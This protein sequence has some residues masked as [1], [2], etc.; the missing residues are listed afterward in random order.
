MTSRAIFCYAYDSVTMTARQE[1]Q[2]MG[3]LYM[4]YVAVRY[5]QAKE[6]N[7]E[8]KR[9]IYHAVISASHA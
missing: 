5:Y 2:P 6:W 8:G 7:K 9:R 3:S 1:N 4:K